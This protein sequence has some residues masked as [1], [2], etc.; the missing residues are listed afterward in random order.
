[1][2][3]VFNGHDHDYERSLVNGVNYIVAG[4]G[5]APL[6]PVG[7]GPHTVYSESTLHVVS[8]SVNEHILTSVGV[9]P[10]GT[11]FD[12]FTMTCTPLLGDLDCDC[13]VGLADIMIVANCWRSTDPE[14]GLYDLDDD[15]DMDIVD[16]M[17]VAV[18]WGEAC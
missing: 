8:V 4:G 16:I 5:G 15:G 2:Q 3:L 18:H 1:M 10:D 7:S 14:C 13:Q 12:R 6:Y 11:T 17:L 9:R